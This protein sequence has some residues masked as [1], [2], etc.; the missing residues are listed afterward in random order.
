MAY[1]AAIVSIGSAATVAT[2]E[3]LAS[4]FHA[5]VGALSAIL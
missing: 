2:R 5:G 3:D 4:Q 1:V